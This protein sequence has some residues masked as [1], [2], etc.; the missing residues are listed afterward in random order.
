MWHFLRGYVILQIEGFSIAW[1]LRRMSQNGV[2]VHRAVRIDP[3]CVRLEIDAKRFFALHRLH[4]GLPVRIRIL[5]KRGL[6]FVRRKLMARPVLW[7]GTLLLGAGLVWASQ[8]IWTIRVE[9]NERI[10]TATLFEALREHGL[11]VGRRPMS[12]VLITAAND[13]SASIPEAAWIGLD[14]EGVVLTVQIVENVPETA[15]RSQT[16]PSDVIAAADGVILNLLVTH[17]QARV[18]VGDK[19]RAGDVLI[20]GTV[21]YKDTSYET[22]ADG[23]VTAA[24]VYRAECEAQ[25]SVTE[26]VESGAE[27]TLR[28]VRFGPYTVFGGRSPFEQYRV[29]NKRTV[30]VSDRLPVE[31]DVFTVHELVERTRILD[32]EEA[33]QLA[34]IDAREQALSLLPRDAA[35]LHQYGILIQ[36]N[37]KTVAVVTVIA[38]QTIGRTE[39]RPHGGKHGESD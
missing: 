11:S 28:A 35:V 32:P 37:N 10:E 1:L 13:L 3:T 8:R 14:R 33:E 4:R 17:G 9:G 21:V 15:K 38:E 31:M 23:V 26:C 36:N 6:P 12:A 18:A 5:E 24:V 29:A 2:R 22:W 34:L 27:A 16:I 39:E 30:A 25:E 7:L 19:V 20:S